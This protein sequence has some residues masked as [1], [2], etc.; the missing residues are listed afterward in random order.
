[1]ARKPPKCVNA[2]R[3]KQR[4]NQKLYYY[5]RREGMKKGIP[6]PGDPDSEAF[7]IAYGEAL[8][9]TSNMAVDAPAEIGAGRIRPGTIAALTANYLKSVA[10]LGLAKDTRQTRWPLLERFRE[11]YGHMPV[12]LLRRDH[13][14]ILLSKIPSP[15]MKDHWLRTIRG[16]LKSGV[17]AMLG[18]DPTKGIKVKQIKT[19]GHHTWTE[20][21]I[22]QYRA[23]HP[24]GTQAR[25]VLEFAL[26]SASRKGEIVRL[27]PQ[28]L[29]R[30]TN[31]QWRI[32]IERTKGKP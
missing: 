11:Q 21:E 15:A 29:H 19:A 2:Y 27:G 23:H 31:G 10:W 5:F 17:P 14:E 4:K 18:D 24:L 7:N 28:H 16:L 12:A 9:R 20:S 3:N 30:D 32:K 1:M 26:E 6:L 25:L 22:V 13:I 8:A